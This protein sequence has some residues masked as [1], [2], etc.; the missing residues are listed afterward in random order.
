LF[1]GE[2]FTF[3]TSTDGTEGVQNMKGTIKYFSKAQERLNNE[4]IPSV[5]DDTLEYNKT[6]NFS[7]S[8]INKI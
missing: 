5:G 7:F 8:F 3:R 4:Q 1:T 6:I 2:I